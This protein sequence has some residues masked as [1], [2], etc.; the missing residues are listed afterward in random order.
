MRDGLLR[1]CGGEGASTDSVHWRRL[2]ACTVAVVGASTLAGTLVTQVEV[3]LHED[4][5]AAVATRKLEC[6]ASDE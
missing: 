3:V 4:G 2:A 1:L 5:G 6:R